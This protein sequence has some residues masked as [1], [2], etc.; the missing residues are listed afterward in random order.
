MHPFTRSV[1]NRKATNGAP[2]SA[3][4][5]DIV[6]LSNDCIVI[7]CYI[8]IIIIIITFIS[9]GKHTAN[10][11]HTNREEKTVKNTPIHKNQESDEYQYI[12][13]HRN[14][15]AVLSQ[16]NRTMLQLLFSV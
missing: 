15:K 1:H 14:K 9:G 8:I 7:H 5:A 16:G 13:A 6:R 11:K 2:D 10:N 4:V 12:V 3:P